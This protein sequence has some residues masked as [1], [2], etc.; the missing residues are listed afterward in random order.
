MAIG[1][2]SNP[3][4]P[5]QLC[6][7]PA[8]GFSVTRELMSTGQ[9]LSL[10]AET[11][12]RVGVLSRSLSPAQLR[13]PP[14]PG[15]WSVNDVVAHLRSCV[16]TRGVTLQRILKEDSPTIRA[17]NPRTWITSTNYLELEF[18]D[19]FAVFAR[20]R[21]DL[22]ETLAQLSP[23]AWTRSALVTGAGAVLTRTAQAF[24]DWL[25]RHERQH[26]RQLEQ[27]SEAVR[28]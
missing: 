12:S 8:G 5:G 13:T 14:G 27:I 11:P 18:H 25:A 6:P 23:E 7:I 20:E 4:M 1:A 2:A 22:L 24:G 28:R 3:S 21:A 26:Y 15:E 9:I 17:I 10:L 19:S 16:D